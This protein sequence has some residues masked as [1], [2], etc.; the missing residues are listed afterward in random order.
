MSER[1][2]ASIVFSLFLPFKSSSM[3]SQTVLWLSLCRPVLRRQQQCRQRR[4]AQTAAA[5]RRS[6]PSAHPCQLEPQ[7][8]DGTAAGGLWM[9][10][11]WVKIQWCYWHCQPESGSGHRASRIS[12]L[13][14][15]SFNNRQFWMKLKQAPVNE[16][17]ILFWAMVDAWSNAAKRK[18]K[19][20]VK[21]VILIFKHPY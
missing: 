13:P 1:Y 15:F 12:A 19:G 5:G 14:A 2:I 20:S 17:L 6:L 18:C 9:S 4:S 8:E 21:G 3:V 11:Q 16:G 7:R 10:L